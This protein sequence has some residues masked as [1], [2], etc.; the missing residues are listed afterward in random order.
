MIGSPAPET[1]AMFDAHYAGAPERKLST[2]AVGQVRAA[3]IGSARPFAFIKRKKTTYKQLRL[4]DEELQETLNK[5]SVVQG[6]PPSFRDSKLCKQV[7]SVP[8]FE[9]TLTFAISSCFANVFLGNMQAEAVSSL[10]IGSDSNAGVGV[11]Q[12]AAGSVSMYFRL[13]PLSGMFNPMLGMCI[14][15]FGLGPML[16]IM[17]LSGALH[18]LSLWLGAF[19]VGA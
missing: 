4:I 16:G 5:N 1:L 2:S 11:S 8:F 14:D 7:F 10:L 6:G 13:A 18:A 15:R 3:A 9:L 17:L 12:L 19:Y